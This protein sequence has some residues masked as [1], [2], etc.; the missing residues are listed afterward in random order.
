MKAIMAPFRGPKKEPILQ[1]KPAIIRIRALWGSNG[2][3]CLSTRERS[4]ATTGA[5]PSQ[6]A[7]H[8]DRDRGHLLL[9]TLFGTM[10]PTAAPQEVAALQEKWRTVPGADAFGGRHELEWLGAV[11]SRDKSC[12]N[13]GMAFAHQHG[14]LASEGA[15]G[16]SSA[17]GLTGGRWRKVARLGG[18]GRP[19]RVRGGVTP[20]CA[21]DEP[22]AGQWPVG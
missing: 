22:P 19:A 18:G 4:T 15:S 10:A 8:V 12:H 17:V 6:P 20:D 13:G 14:G 5:R 3:V 7:P 16:S 21:A 2:L 9:G 11:R 1:G